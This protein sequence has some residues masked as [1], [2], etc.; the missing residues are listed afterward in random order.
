MLIS[1]ACQLNTANQGCSF[2]NIKA[3]SG[4]PI[5]SQTCRS[6]AQDIH[7]YAHSSQDHLN[8]WPLFGFRGFIFR[9]DVQLVSEQPHW[10]Q[11]SKWVH[12]W[13]AEWHN[14]QMD[15]VELPTDSHYWGERLHQTFEG[16]S[17]DWRAIH[18]VEQF[19][20]VTRLT[21]AHLL[22]NQTAESA[23]LDSQKNHIHLM[24]PPMYLMAPPVAA[25]AKTHTVNPPI[26]GR[27]RDTIMIIIWRL[28]HIIQNVDWTTAAL[29]LNRFFFSN[30]FTVLIPYSTKD[31]RDVFTR[32]NNKRKSSEEIYRC[33]RTWR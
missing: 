31:V 27:I 7:I 28:F 12:S 32:K 15:C 5:R 6:A 33:K 21:L 25:H 24:A 2:R 9:S 10:S 20:C 19:F 4:D 14:C 29:W 16:N 26:V 13:Q 11:S 3:T 17:Y 23:G 8:A 18:S 1:C 22:C 30:N